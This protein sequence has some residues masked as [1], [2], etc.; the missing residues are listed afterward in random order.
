MMRI[1]KLPIVLLTMTAALGGMLYGEGAKP[2]AAEGLFDDVNIGLFSI[3]G[4]A[5]YFD[6]KDGDAN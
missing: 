6:P 2:A 3:G 5:T 4:R 1:W